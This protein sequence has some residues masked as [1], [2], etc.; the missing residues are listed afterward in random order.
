MGGLELKI[1]TSNQESPH[2]SPPELAEFLGP[3]LGAD[4]EGEGVLFGN[5]GDDGSFEEGG[6][7]EMPRA[8]SPIPSPNVMPWNIQDR[9]ATT[10]NADSKPFLSYY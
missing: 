8:F 1:T 5:T 7:I 3:G 10:T 2:S 9:T 6:F 4:L